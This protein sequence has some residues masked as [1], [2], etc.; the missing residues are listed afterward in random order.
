MQVVRL[1]EEALCQ[2]LPERAA[3]ALEAAFQMY[4]EHSLLIDGPKAGK[5]AAVVEPGIEAA[6]D[7]IS[8]TGFAARPW[9]SEQAFA[10]Y[11]TGC[12]SSSA[13]LVNEAKS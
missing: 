9:L 8:S 5:W 1:H 7:H 10:Q 12:A 2:Q 3:F 11:S 6:G 4:A 13:N